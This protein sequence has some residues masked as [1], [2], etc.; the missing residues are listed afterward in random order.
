M[1]TRILALCLISIM[2]TG[3]ASVLRGVTVG[4]V[5]GADTGA[6]VD[7]YAYSNDPYMIVYPVCQY[8]EPLPMYSRVG[9]VWMYPHVDPRC[10]YLV[11]LYDS[12]RHG[13][14][15]RSPRYI[16]PPPP[17][18]RIPPRDTRR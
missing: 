2:S 15:I 13:H 4:A 3:C 8:V 17:P 18:R 1:R 14:R 9:I 16:P 10:V 6:I 5:V 11:R 12:M 7:T